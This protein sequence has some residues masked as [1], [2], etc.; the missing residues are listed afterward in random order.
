M[1]TWT[2]SDALG[3]DVQVSISPA[4]GSVPSSGSYTVTPSETTI[5]TLTATNQDGTVSASTTVTVAPPVVTSNT[6]GN[7]SG[8]SGTPSTGNT[9]SPDR[10]NTFWLGLGDGGGTTRSWLSYLV[11]FGLVAAAAVVAIVLVTRRTALACSDD[12]VGTQVALLSSMT[13]CGADTQV[14]NGTER[15]TSFAT[16]STPRLVAADGKHIAISE[17]GRTLG[18]KDLRSLVKTDKI[19]LVSREHIQLTCEDGSYY[20]EDC[21]STN[22]TKVNGS[23]IRGKGKHPLKNGDQIELAGV[24]TLTF[25]SQ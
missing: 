20:V 25:Q 21:N 14:A 5:Y 9:A 19:G 1:L 11:L 16:G 7:T 12:R 15:T 18:R 3:R 13:S 6:G 10:H 23:S 17:G 24:V 8:G 2:V 4:I 22:G